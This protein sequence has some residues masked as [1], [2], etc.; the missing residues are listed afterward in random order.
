MAFVLPNLYF[1]VG[2]VLMVLALSGF[3]VMVMET[4]LMAGC[5]ALCIGT[6]IAPMVWGMSVTIGTD[7]RMAGEEDA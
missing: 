5:L 2:F 6:I 7:V 4:E 3:F 1:R